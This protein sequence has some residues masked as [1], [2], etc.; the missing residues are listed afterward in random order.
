MLI[1][2]QLKCNS[3]AMNEY[4]VKRIPTP[5]R[6]LSDLRLVVILSFNKNTPGA[7]VDKLK[8]CFAGG[9]ILTGVLRLMITEIRPGVAMK[10]CTVRSLGQPIYSRIVS[11]HE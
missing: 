1:S 3:D 11:L 6:D 2:A 4:M 7:E 9:S 8:C 10:D 5:M